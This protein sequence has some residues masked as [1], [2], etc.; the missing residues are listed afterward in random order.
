MALTAVRDHVAVNLKCL[1]LLQLGMSDGVQAAWRT[2]FFL[3]DI[4]ARSA[5]DNGVGLSDPEGRSLVHVALLIIVVAK[6]HRRLGVL[7]GVHALPAIA[8]VVA[9]LVKT[10]TISFFHFVRIRKLRT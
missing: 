9:E 6:N 3:Q 1:S 2:G 7:P 8:T 4:A 10:I 5:I